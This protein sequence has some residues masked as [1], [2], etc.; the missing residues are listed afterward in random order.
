[1]P[2]AHLPKIGYGFFHD[3]MPFAFPAPPPRLGIEH[4]NAGIANFVASS[5]VT[6][7]VRERLSH[8]LEPPTNG[9]RRHFPF[10]RESFARTQT[11][12]SAITNAPVATR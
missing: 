8:V 2:L 7:A 11:A 9:L 12:S 6:F 5:L 1:M 3:P 10:D 4:E